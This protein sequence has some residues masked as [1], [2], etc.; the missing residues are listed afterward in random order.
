MRNR[1]IH[2]HSVTQQLT[3]VQFL[4]PH[5]RSMP[6]GIDGVIVSHGDIAEYSSPEAN[7]DV[8]RLAR[9][10]QLHFLD[11]STIRNRTMLPRDR[12]KG[13]GQLDVAG[14]SARVSSTPAPAMPGAFATAS[15]MRAASLS[16]PT[17]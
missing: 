9:D 15:A 13:A 17:R 12:R 4:H 2:V 10:G 3:V 14:S 1:H 11:G 7:V 6:K 5:R 16:D 8:V